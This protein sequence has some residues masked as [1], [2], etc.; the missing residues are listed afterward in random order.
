MH[1]PTG[2]T[3]GTT[4]RLYDVIEQARELEQR[5]QLQEA[6]AVLAIAR[7]LAKDAPKPDLAT[8]LAIQ[9]RLLDAT[10]SRYAL[11]YT[12]PHTSLATLRLRL[13]MLTTSKLQHASLVGWLFCRTRTPWRQKVAALLSNAA[14]G[15]TGSSRSMSR[16]CPLHPPI[17][18]PLTTAFVAALQLSGRDSAQTGSR[19]QTSLPRPRACWSASA[20]ALQLLQCW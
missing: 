19:Y 2:N 7:N 6:L 14:I 5:H 3:N 16:I 4:G 11:I 18:M 9:A 10:D 12:K 8:V 20:S 1:T 17:V 13:R 15:D